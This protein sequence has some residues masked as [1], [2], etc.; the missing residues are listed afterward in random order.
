MSIAAAPVALAM[1]AV[2]GLLP[3]TTG[4]VTVVV[5]VAAT[6]M[7]LAVV[8]GAIEIVVAAATSG[9]IMPEMVVAV[10][11]ALAV[12]AVG[13][14]VTMRE[15]VVSPLGTILD[16]RQCRTSSSSRASTSL[17]LFTAHHRHHPLPISWCHSRLCHML[18]PLR[19]LVS[20]KFILPLFA[21][22]SYLFVVM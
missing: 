16:C 13:I 8:T 4:M 2:E 20:L 19:T 7:A 21:I 6:V 12:V 10:A 3:I 1:T 9:T 5:V 15:G 14:A 18:R 11:M 22:S 17:G